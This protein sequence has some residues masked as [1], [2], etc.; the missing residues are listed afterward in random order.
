MRKLQL[1]IKKGVC[2]KIALFLCMALSFTFMPI[3]MVQAA[4]ETAKQID[5]ALYQRVC[6]EVLSGKITNEEDVLKVALAQYENRKNSASRMGGKEQDDSLTIT[7]V[8]DSRVDNNGNVV[9]DVITTDLLVLDQNYSLASA[10]DV[11][12][13]YA[14]LSEFS[15]YATMN[16]SVTYDS[17]DAKVRFN[18][19]NT[20]LT[21]GTAMKASSLTQSSTISEVFFH[22]T[23]PEKTYIN[24]TAGYKYQ[25][26]PSNQTMVS[27]VTLSSGRACRSIIKAGSK[28]FTLAYSFTAETC[29][30]N[31]GTWL[32]EYK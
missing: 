19:F 18:W 23:E 17:S 27:Y 20:V 32:T 26:T 10:T 9:E 3:D 5:D 14:N 13:G 28:T 31:Q 1:N 6:D 2:G 15:I 21:Y 8:V 25:Y 11:K 29:N 4:E 12:T 16:V 22:E 30:Q 24:P 7:Q